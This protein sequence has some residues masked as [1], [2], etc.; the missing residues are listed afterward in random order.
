M[1]NLTKTRWYILIATIV[2][3]I[4]IG[5]A[6]AWSVFQA[7][8][9]K[10][11]NSIFGHTVTKQQLAL[12]FTICS[13]V[14]PVCMILGPTLQ[15]KLGSP[16]IVI[17]AG[18]ILFGLGLILSGFISKLWMLYLTYGIVCGFGS[19]L[20]YGITISNTVRLC[21]DKKGLASGLVTAAF[22]AGAIIFPPVI[23]AIINTDGTLKAFK[24][25]GLLFIVLVLIAGFFIKEAPIGFVPENY[26]Q[27]VYNNKKEIPSKN[28]KGMLKD[29][30]FYIMISIFTIFATAG[31]ML[32]S[33]GSQISQAVGH[34]NAEKAAIIVSI[35]AI[36]NTLGRLIFGF[37]SD[38]IGS[39]KTLLI[40]TSLVTLCSFIL[41][42]VINNEI[43]I[44]F[45]ILAVI[46][47]MCYGGSMGVY[48]SLTPQTFGLK[49]NGVNYGIMFIGFALGSYFGPVIANSLFEASNSYALSLLIVAVLGFIGFIL[50]N[51]FIKVN[52]KLSKEA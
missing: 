17:W 33:Q 50:V 18:G 12:A 27:R 2:V 43:L 20:A 29:I 24:V 7:G 32:I 28:W 52:K 10:E 1:K 22:G 45:I 23:N 16:R 44:A 30:R 15:K 8:L 40:M 14:S 34:I 37:V 35:I 47:A 13:G 48:P 42:F 5:T 39:N 19:A 31:L 26:E 3:N 4:C 38:K 6:F 36:G 21:P 41:Y 9:S 46:V 25:L 49:Y 51:V 11:A